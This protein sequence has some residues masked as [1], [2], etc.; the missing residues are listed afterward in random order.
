MRT[1]YVTVCTLLVCV[2]SARADVVVDWNVIAANTIAAGARP[3]P[4]GLF[5]FTMVHIAMHDAIQAL[6]HRFE[7]Y[8]CTVAGASGSP[9]VAAARAAHDMLVALFPAQSTSL[10]TTYLDYLSGLGLSPANEGA[11]VGQQCAADIFNLRAGD[12]RFPVNPV[13]FLGGTGPGEWRPTAFANGTPLPMT[14]SWIGDVTPFAL[15]YSSQLRASNG[16]PYLTSGHYARDYNEVKAMGGLENSA[17]T[18]EQTQLA[19]FYA[20]S[21]NVY[22]NRS[23]RGIASTY[24]TRIGDSARLFALANIALADALITSWN[25]KIYWNFWRP[26]TAIHEGANDG[27]PRTAGDPSW[28]PLLIT[29]NYPDYTSNASALAGA[30][31]TML[32]RFFGT[33]KLAFSMTTVFPAGTPPKNRSYTRFSDVARDVVNV[34]VWQ[35]IHFRFADTVGE[36]QG[37]HIAQWTFTRLLRPVK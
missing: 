34:R 26:I 27:N 24:L 36:R 33:D 17:R 16:P 15:E 10:Q 13:P 12:G 31:T 5:D 19:F 25:T 30:G 2:G 7:P 18:P 37:A 6:E 29:P 21:S 28:Q 3:G 1:I 35:G 22:W 14:A 9:V 23:L 11:L 20:E 4:S 32:K 8:H